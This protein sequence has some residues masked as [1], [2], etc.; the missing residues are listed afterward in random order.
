VVV[1]LYASSSMY[2]PRSLPI[3]IH[4]L[5]LHHK[6]PPSVAAQDLYYPTCGGMPEGLT[7]IQS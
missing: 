6:C 4:T 3:A 2:G 1:C 5:E 7:P